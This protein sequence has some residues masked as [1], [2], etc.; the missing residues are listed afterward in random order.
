MTS[1]QEIKE[2]FDAANGVHS[3]YLIVV[4][5]TFD[6]EDYP[7]GVFVPITSIEEFWKAFD[8]HNGLNMQKIMEVYE[9]A[10]GW[11]D[12]SGAGHLVM[13]LPERP[14]APTEDQ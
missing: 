8:E 11:P 3:L 4:C 6:W 12:H 5:D 1:R 13:Q 7:L 14:F 2:W 9:I 10:K